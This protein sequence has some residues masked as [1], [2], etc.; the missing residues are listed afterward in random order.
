MFPLH[1]QLFQVKGQCQQEQLRADVALAPCQKP[2]EPKVIFEQAK[3]PL[4]LDGA[5]ETQVNPSLRHNILLRLSPFLPEGFLEYKLL[6]VLP[7]KK[8]H[9]KTMIPILRKLTGCTI[10]RNF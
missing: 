2:A 3:G 9:Y 7:L 6:Q 10:K 4:H 1:P 5:A 8:S